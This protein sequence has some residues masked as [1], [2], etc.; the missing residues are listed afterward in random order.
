MPIN[1]KEDNKNERR[2]SMKIST[3]GKDVDIYATVEEINA[4]LSGMNSECEDDYYRNYNKEIE[5]EY[6]DDTNKLIDRIYADILR[7]A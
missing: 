1:F 5:D 2:N 3:R 6:I 7:S 4:M